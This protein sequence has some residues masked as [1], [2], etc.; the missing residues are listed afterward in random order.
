ADGLSRSFSTTEPTAEDGS[1][2]TVSEDWEASRGIVQDLLAVNISATEQTILTDSLDTS[3]LTQRFNNDPFFLDIIQALLDLDLD[4][5]VRE[6]RKA[7]HR[8]QNF[9]IAEGKLWRV[10]NTTANRAH[11]KLE[12]VTREEA[13]DLAYQEH[14]ENGHW[15]RDLVKLRLM[16]KIFC[17]RLDRII[18]DAI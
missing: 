7:R 18:T 13:Q 5:T 16:D 4:K 6:K 10:A 17:P 8:A 2:W 15:G 9:F 14:K 11:S 3:H 12:C 1:A